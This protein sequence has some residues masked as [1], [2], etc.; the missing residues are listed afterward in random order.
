MNNRCTLIPGIHESTFVCQ[1]I[2]M[3]GIGLPGEKYEAAREVSKWEMKGREEKDTNSHSGDDKD[4]LTPSFS[5]LILPLP[6]SEA[7]IRSMEA[8]SP[9]IA[10]SHNPFD[11]ISLAPS[12]HSG[13]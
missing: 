3:S 1:L 4:L 13:R 8:K 7:V 11:M 12:L 6:S 5:V 10:Y 2:Q 9:S